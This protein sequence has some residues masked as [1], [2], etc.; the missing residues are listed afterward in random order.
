[1]VTA[2]DSATILGMHIPYYVLTWILIGIVLGFI[3]HKRV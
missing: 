1:M 3:I 2:A